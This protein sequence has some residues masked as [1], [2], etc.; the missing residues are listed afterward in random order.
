MVYKCENCDKVYKTKDCL[1]VHIKLKHAA[2]ESL[3]CA[4]WINIQRPSFSL[5]DL[6]LS[7]ILENNAYMN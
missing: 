7:M 4:K 3:Q 2:I 6:Y 5:L 1:R